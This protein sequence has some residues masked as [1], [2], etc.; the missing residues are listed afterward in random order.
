MRD[1]TINSVREAHYVRR[2]GLTGKASCLNTPVQK[3]ADSEQ[4]NAKSQSAIA[5]PATAIWLAEHAFPECERAIAIFHADF[6]QM[7]LDI[8]LRIVEL[9]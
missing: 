2:C 9:I 5:L 3:N 7:I 6:P 4:K 1:R 8:L